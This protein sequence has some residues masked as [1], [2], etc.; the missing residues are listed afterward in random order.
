MSKQKRL[1]IIHGRASKPSEKEKR[2]LAE[3]ALFNGL[4][5]VS[6][7]AAKRLEDKSIKYDFV[8]YGDINNRELMNNDPEVKQQLKG[9][10]P[11][12]NNSPC[13]VDGSYDADMQKLFE[14][15]TFS[16]AAYRKFLA[17]TKDR[18]M[19]DE[20]VSV[21]S[22]IANLLGLSDNVIKGA[23]PD[24]GAYLQT[25]KVGSEVRTR[26]QRQLK[27]AIKNNEDICLVSHSMGCIVS[28]DVLWKFSQMSEYADVRENGNRIN[29]WL[30]LG[31]P[32]GEPGVRDNLYDANER[33]DGKYPRGI[34]N[35]W[36]NIAARDDFVSH[37]GT[38][39]ND[40]REMKKYVGSIKD[41]PQIHNF[42]CGTN[43]SNPHKLYGYLDNPKVAQ[44][45]A[46]WIMA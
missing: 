2:R 37:D 36:V 43:G 46:N 21:I 1:I 22:A 27:P 32:L 13:E 20:A 7:E 38:M 33:E 26:L 10:D 40:Y 31:N 42:W 16:R 41:R 45:I 6:S 3:M 12:H 39:E 18:R 15:T 8:Y 44:E 9:R 25:R 34:I 14:Q 23:T 11:Q 29:L 35:R 5:R 19:M 17:E 4:R 28:Y 24:M 30:T